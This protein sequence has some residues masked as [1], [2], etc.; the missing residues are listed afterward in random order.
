[1]N[2][3]L[4]DHF[5]LEEMTISGWASRNKISNT[6]T[7]DEYDNLLIA[8][9]GMEKVRNILGNKPIIVTSGYRNTTVNAGIGGSKT[10][11]HMKGYAVDF[12]C[13]RF[14]TPIEICRQIEKSGLKYDQL[15]QEGTWVHISFDPRMRNQILTKTPTGFKQGL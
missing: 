10:S 7:K 15:I 1:M 12:V 4:T 11:A 14:G 3:K 2:T 6:P 8:A 13:P 5:T 9:E